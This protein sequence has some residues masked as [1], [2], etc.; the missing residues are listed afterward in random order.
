MIFQGV[1]LL[2]TKFRALKISLGIRSKAK[3]YLPRSHNRTILS[4]KKKHGK[5]WMAIVSGSKQWLAFS[6]SRAICCFKVG[7]SFMYRIDELLECFVMGFIETAD[8]T[9]FRYSRFQKLA[10]FCL[11]LRFT[12][13]FLGLFIPIAFNWFKRLLG[14]YL[15]AINRQNMVWLC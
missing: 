5:N 6:P 13:Q 8:G 1:Y 12:P 11:R 15:H 9:R 10:C 7:L 3:S 14:L 4:L 2:F